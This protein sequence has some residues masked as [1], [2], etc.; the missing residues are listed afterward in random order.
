MILHSLCHMQ[1]HIHNIKVQQALAT[2][3]HFKNTDVPCTHQ[4][5]YKQMVNVAVHT[6][7]HT[8]RWCI[9]MRRGNVSDQK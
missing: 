3:F 2:G 1:Y 8:T 5:S 4:N 9:G 6:P 7:Q